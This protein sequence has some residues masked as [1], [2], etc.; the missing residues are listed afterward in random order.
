[1]NEK[2]LVADDEPKFCRLIKLFLD[3]AG[4]DAASACDGEQLLRATAESPPDLILLDAMMPRLDGFATVRALRSNP[5]TCSIPIIM[6]SARGDDEFVRA[7][8]EQ[9]VNLFLNKPFS[10]AE[11]LSFVGRVLASRDEA[12]CVAS[13]QART[14]GVSARG[15]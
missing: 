11:L 5:A 1:M 9:D 7:A 13:A 3:H 15:F 12:R 10:R 2:I 6:F 8:W 4:Y 14:E